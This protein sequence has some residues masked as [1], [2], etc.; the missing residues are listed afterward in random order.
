M[1]NP[2]LSVIVTAHAEGLLAHKT[3]LSIEQ[4]LSQVKDSYE[5][6]IHID[7]GDKDTT[8]YFSRYEN[9]RNIRI[10]KNNFK[11]AGLSRNFAAN[12]SKGKYLAFLD[13]DDLISKNWYASA[14][15]ILKKTKEPVIVH[16]AAN[17]TFGTNLGNQVLWLQ[18]DSF[19]LTETP[20]CLPGLICGRLVSLLRV[21][22]F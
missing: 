3:M 20:F 2:V 7:N 12:K 11:D 9:N 17:L 6:I 16:T 8:K 5:I 15:R 22:C 4:A 19:D 21:R 13:A 18:K 14:L 1:S 10:Y